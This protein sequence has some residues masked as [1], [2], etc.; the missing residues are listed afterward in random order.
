MPPPMNLEANPYLKSKLGNCRLCG[1]SPVAVDARS[2]PRCGAGNP[3]PGLG[4]RWG[5]RGAL[6]GAVGAGGLEAVWGFVNQYAFSGIII[7]SLFVA[8]VGALI[9]LLG[10]MAAG[11]MARLF[12][13]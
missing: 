1:H 3:N 9:G 2:C 4:S 13:K 11:G 6:I 12:N 5:A 10:G 8:V 7:L